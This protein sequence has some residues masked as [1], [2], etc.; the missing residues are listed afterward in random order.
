M[1][2]FAEKLDFK[3][4]SAFQ[5]QV[6]IEV[7]RDAYRRRRELIVEMRKLGRDYM[8]TVT[9]VLALLEILSEVFKISIELKVK[10]MC[11]AVATISLIW[12]YLIIETRD[13]LN[14]V[15]SVINTFYNKIFEDPMPLH[16]TLKF[17]IYVALLLIYAVTMLVIFLLI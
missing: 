14:K 5:I 9:A 12:F 2:Y 6:L 7:L 16:D 3:K 11:G 17:R 15:E 1:I 10:T 4:L 13:E 8:A